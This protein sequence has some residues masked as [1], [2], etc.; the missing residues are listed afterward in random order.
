MY[1]FLLR[2]GR[3][4]RSFLKYAS[5]GFSIV[6][7]F[8]CLIFVQGLILVAKLDFVFLLRNVLLGERRN[9]V[10]ELTRFSLQVLELV[11][12]LELLQLLLCQLLFL[13]LPLI[14]R[15]PVYWIINSQLLLVLEVLRDMPRHH[16][17]HQDKWDNHV[18]EEIEVIG[19]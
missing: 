4:S 2:P 6:L 13:L 19:F 1:L 3:G 15:D 12:V 7:L 5:R 18:L 8:F 17:Q 11:G 14:L 9:V 16:G 10:L